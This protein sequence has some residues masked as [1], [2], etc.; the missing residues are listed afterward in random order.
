MST[1]ILTECTLEVGGMTCASC[2]R[3]V[4]KALTELE[5]VSAAHVDLAAETATVSFD[6]D[7]VQLEDLTTA[8]GAAGYT[9][10]PRATDRTPGMDPRPVPAPPCSRP[11]STTE[12][13]SGTPS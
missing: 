6:P 3:R 8:L 1:Q 10:R 11:A 13:T 2:V 4:E 9:G 12:G 5:G 7:T